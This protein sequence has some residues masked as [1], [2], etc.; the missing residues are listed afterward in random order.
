MR[1]VQVNA[2]IPFA[3]CSTVILKYQMITVVTL[4]C[5]MYL[6]YVHELPLRSS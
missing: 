2:M 3:T 1:V 5:I 6:Y 4:I